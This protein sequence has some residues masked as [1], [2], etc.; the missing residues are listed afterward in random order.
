MALDFKITA[1][2][3]RD[4]ARALREKAK[5]L[6]QAAEVL[7]PAPSQQALLTMNPPSAGLSGRHAVSA[8]LFS[9][10]TVAKA[11]ETILIE[12]G[13][14]LSREDIFNRIKERGGSVSSVINL[15]SALS[16]ANN[17]F[18]SLGNSVWDLKE[19]PIG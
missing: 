11:A 6:D 4:E 14:P 8:K 5:Q 1:E 17:K 16:R 9:D 7:D 3:L 13:K 10:F 12:A 2:G 15:V 18:V 19:R